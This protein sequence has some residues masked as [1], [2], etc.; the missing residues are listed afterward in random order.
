MSPGWRF[1]R[2]SP[3]P[4]AT[5]AWIEAR[6]RSIARALERALAKPTGGWFALD[7]SRRI[8]R[9]PR[10]YA[11]DGRLLIAWRGDGVLRVA[12]EA[13]P[14]M[15]ASLAGARICEGAVVCP[16]HGLPLTAKGH[17]AWHHLPAF[18]D[19]VLAWVR[20]DGVEEPTERPVLPVRPQRA[21]DGVIRIEAR[22]DPRDVL[23][24][25][26]DP[27]HGESF[28]PYSFG[29]LRVLDDDGDTLTV[30]VEKLVL[31]PLRVEVDATF[32]C[33]DARTIVMTIVRGEGEGSVV[34][35]HATPLAN[36]RTAILEATLATSPRKGFRHVLFLRRLLRPLIERSARRLW[37]DDARY[38][39]RL[40]ELRAP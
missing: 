9:S 19:G 34:E 36:G 26:L 22:C 33:P 15:G 24:N 5:P 20:I 6:P 11:V 31:G 13:C 14:H 27:W 2:R 30:R 37:I 32:H 10:V 25:R 8:G 29:A 35:T 23:A 4:D 7:A 28:H 12:P 18:E 21:L 38:A 3:E 1:T 16:W 40:R 17:A 39:E